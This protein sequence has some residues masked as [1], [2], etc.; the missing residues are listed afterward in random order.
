MSEAVDQHELTLPAFETRPVGGLLLHADRQFNIALVVATV[1]HLLFLVSFISA[2]SRHLGDP[3]G[4]RGG[5]SVDF[6][7]EADLKSMG[8]VADR[9]AGPLAPPT[10]PP[11]PPQQ[12]KPAP[13][14]EPPPPEPQAQPKADPPPQQ[15]AA[16]PAEP[17][18]PAPQE[19]PKAASPDKPA[20]LPDPAV[21]QLLKIPTQ[22]ALPHTL[23]P[24]KPPEPA[25]PAT[26]AKTEQARRAPPKQSQVRTS[27]LDLS[28]PPSFSAPSGGGGAGIQ[29]PAGITRSGEN[30]AFARGVIAALQR[31]MPQLRETRGRVTVRIKL[32]KD[33]GLVGTEIMVPSSVAGLDQSVVFSTRQASFPFPPR[34]AN[35]ADLTFLVTYIY[36]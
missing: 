32:D 19:Q 25:K 24:P 21:E 3:G 1:A 29:R 13:Q 9:A 22:A 30:D 36:R 12:Q 27:S 10:P 6:V 20:M 7:S 14:P 33:G 2:E 23:D 34:N 31:S 18:P 15:T 17:P 11:E 4:A 26:P 5:I 8:T 16:L 35:A 28:L